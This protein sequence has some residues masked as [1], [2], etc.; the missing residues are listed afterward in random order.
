MNFSIAMNADKNVVTSRECRQFAGK[1][2]GA[3]QIL[4]VDRR[5]IPGSKVDGAE[6]QKETT[7]QIVIG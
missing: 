2:A 1:I 4:W 6:G 7:V 5:G 3:A